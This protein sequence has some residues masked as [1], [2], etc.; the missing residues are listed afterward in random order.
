M[1]RQES[2]SSD[3]AALAVVDGG[4]DFFGGHG[5]TE[6][7][8]L[9]TGDFQESKSPKTALGT[10]FFSSLAKTGKKVQVEK[11]AEIAR[12]GRAGQGDVYSFLS[13][14]VRKQVSSSPSVDGTTGKR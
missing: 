4:D 9:L 3:F 10:D 13:R 12:G 7:V 1:E 5:R 2:F 11:K 6:S 14:F 8:D